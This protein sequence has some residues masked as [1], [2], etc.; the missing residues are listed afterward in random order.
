[1]YL[2]EESETNPLVIFVFHN[3]IFHGDWADTRVGHFRAN[4]GVQQL[5]EGEG[6][7]DPAVSVHHSLWHNLENIAR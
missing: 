7:V 1:M 6:G 2:E 3:F 5:R 4:I